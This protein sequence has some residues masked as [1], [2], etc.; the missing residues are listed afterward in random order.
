M[1]RLRVPSL[2]MS[3]EGYSAGPRQDLANPLGVG[4]CDAR[5]RTL[6]PSLSLERDERKK[7]A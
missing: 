3:I 6:R 7:I 4:G 2:P 1:T 5:G